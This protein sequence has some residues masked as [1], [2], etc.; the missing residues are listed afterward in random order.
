[1]REVKIGMK[2]LEEPRYMKMKEYI[3]TKYNYLAELG[4]L[5]LGEREGMEVDIQWR[6]ICDM[7]EYIE[8]IDLYDDISKNKVRTIR[9]DR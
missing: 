4:R 9:V 8:Q 7:T 6:M 3:K 1:M 2:Y 5:E